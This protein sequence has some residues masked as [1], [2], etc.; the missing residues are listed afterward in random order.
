MEAGLAAGGCFFVLSIGPAVGL[1]GQ[2]FFQGSFPANKEQFLRGRGEG[3]TVATRSP[4][5][6]DAHSSATA[7]S[8]PSSSS[9]PTPT[10]S[11]GDFQWRRKRINSGKQQTLLGSRPRS[12]CQCNGQTRVGVG[13]PN[14]LSFKINRFPFR[15]KKRWAYLNSSLVPI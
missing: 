12:P 10:R 3:E 4:S 11:I 9:T 13:F 7:S 8:A 15:P 1:R 2:G 14:F 5:T 6:R